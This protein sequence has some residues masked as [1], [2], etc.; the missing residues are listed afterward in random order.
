MIIIFINN[1]LSF[2]I[3]NILQNLTITLKNKRGENKKFIQKNC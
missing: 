1:I 2:K 3:I